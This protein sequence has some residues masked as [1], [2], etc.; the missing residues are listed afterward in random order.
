[1][2]C[3]LSSSRLHLQTPDYGSL[4]RA[5][6]F[7]AEKH[8]DQRRKGSNKAP[9]INH[10]IDVACII[11]I[12]GGI[13]DVSVLEAA[14][15]HDTIE[16]TDTTAAEIE[17]HFGADVASLVVEMTDDM[18][19]PSAERKAH[20]VLRAPSLSTRAKYIKLG[21]KIANVRDIAHHPPPEWTLDRRKNYFEWTA[22][23]ID[24]CRGV[25][26]GLE[27]RYDQVLAEARRLVT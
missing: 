23:V 25:N 18:S 26:A 4:L 6:S 22:K 13:S 20:Q 1:L 2:R 8:R 27:R 16:D 10:P 3:T 5:L 17:E 7:A 24:G 15:L 9:Y 12:D 19:L 11:A 14:I 21:D